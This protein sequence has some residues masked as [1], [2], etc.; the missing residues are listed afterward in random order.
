MFPQSTNPLTLTKIISGL[1]KSVNIVNQ[2]IPLYEQ[3]KPMI[4]SVKKIFS[5]LNKG[6]DNANKT[7][8]N[9]I[10]KTE[11]PK[12]VAVKSNLNNPTFFLN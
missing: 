11:K 12:K 4:N 1:S 9:Q 10:P 2:V 7:V 8:E 5:Y 3:S 6:N